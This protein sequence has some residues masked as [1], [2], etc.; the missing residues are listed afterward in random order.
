M[1]RYFRRAE[2]SAKKIALALALGL[3][4]AAQADD[5]SERQKPASKEPLGE[6]Q[7]NLPKERPFE[8]LALTLEDDFF[9]P[10][11]NEDRNYTGGIFLQASGR[12]FK[13]TD[14]SAAPLERLFGLKDFAS[15]GV[16]HALRFGGR[17]FTPQDIS[18][19]APILDDRPY[20]ALSF[21]AFDK[22]MVRASSGDFIKISFSLG[23]LGLDLQQ[24]AQTYIHTKKREW[25]DGQHPQD[26]QG[27]A[28]QVSNGG[29]LTGLYAILRQNQ[30]CSLRLGTGSD[31]E[32]FFNLSYYGELEAGYYTDVSAGLRFR[33]GLIRSRDWGLSPQP[34]LG[35]A[36][37][38]PVT[39]SGS[40]LERFDA[41]VFGGGGGR[42]T[43]Y[44][45]L[46]QGGF[47]PAPVAVGF[48]EVAHST[49]EWELGATLGMP[50]I[51]SLRYSVLGRTTEFY[52]PRA[53]D[54]VWG[55]ITLLHNTEF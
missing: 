19:S 32:P 22:A 47:R 16:R 28:N 51:V 1:T 30:L 45:E 10:P 24:N 12:A 2:P 55:S 7:L 36:L 17:A 8:G 46:L 54:Q 5:V 37:Q 14:L 49:A 26:P 27:W 29:E 18:Q 35:L 50:D 31:R 23:A 43:A 15:G 38:H 52:G 39:G 3:A 9:Y 41:Y 6:T 33:V 21:V 48:N 25:G 42:L 20:A 53:D 34:G 11:K 40:L 44:N 13:F 4:A